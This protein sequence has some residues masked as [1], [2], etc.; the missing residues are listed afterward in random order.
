MFHNDDD[1]GVNEK[2]SQKKEARI[3]NVPKLAAN[4]EKDKKNEWNV[5][6]FGIKFA[7]FFFC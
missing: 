2:H 1:D 6:N 4:H 7:V 3:E 5:T